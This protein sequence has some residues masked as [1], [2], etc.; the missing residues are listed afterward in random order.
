MQSVQAVTAELIVEGHQNERMGTKSEDTIRHSYTGSL[1]RC[2]EKHIII[3]IL[4]NVK[5][6]GKYKPKGGSKYL[7]EK[8]EKSRYA[9]HS[10]Q[11]ALQRPADCQCHVA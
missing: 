5:T 9:L 10:S 1:T 11:C 3:N 7:I 8:E 2:L 6:P 4:K